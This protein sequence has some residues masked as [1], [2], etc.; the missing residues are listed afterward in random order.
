[1]QAF[2][3]LASLAATI[4]LV[5]LTRKYVELTKSI[6]STSAAQQ[7]AW[8]DAQEDAHA[9]AVAAFHGH[10][11]RIQSELRSLNP[12]AP[13]EGELR[14]LPVP[15]HDDASLLGSLAAQV[16]ADVS[17]QIVGIQTSI[18]LI[19]DLVGRV[20][21]VAPSMGYMFSSFETSDYARA[22]G[23]ALTPVRAIVVRERAP[24]TASAR[25][26]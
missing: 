11:A 2:A 13:Q 12:D 3:A 5:L 23:D 19:A 7:K 22:R 15:S 14:R 26:S 1:M 17:L 8:L 20:R 6:A 16:S 4:G 18:R 9:R 25:D 21:A 24:L 10:I